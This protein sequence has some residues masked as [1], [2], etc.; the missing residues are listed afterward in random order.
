MRKFF[1]LTLASLLAVAAWAQD[2]SK[3]SVSTQMFL[4]EQAG[5]ISFEKKADFARGPKR[6]GITDEMVAQ[7]AKYDRPIA[8]PV[9]VDGVKMI[10]AFVRVSDRSVV[11]ELEALGVVVE[12]E[13][14]DGT[15]FTTLIPVDKIA[16]VS[17][18]AKVSRIK[19][20]TKRR[21]LTNLARQDANVDDVLTYSTSARDAGLPNAYDGSGVLLG[22]IDTGID[23]QH[24]A[25]KDKD[26]NFRIK[27]AYCVT[28]SGWN[29]SAKEYGDGASNSLSSSAPT[30]DNSS[31]DH[32][33]HTS[34]TAGGSSVIIS[35]SSTTVTDDHAS[36]SY[37]GMAPGADLYLAGCD[38]SDTYLAN[39]FQKIVSYADSKGAP[40]VVSNSWGSQYGPH[41]GTGEFADITS[42]YFS[43]DN[44]NHI[45]LFAASN[46]AGTNGFS[47]SGT[48]TSSNPLGTVLNYNSDYGLTYFYGVLASAWTRSTNT[49][50]ACKLVVI[51]SS[52]VKQTE[53]SVNPSTNGSNVSLGSTYA[54]GT[55]VAYR[56]Y[57]EGSN[58]SQ[59]L[60]YTD[61]LQMRSGYK[62]AVQ[63]YPTNGSSVVDVWSGSA[64]TYYTSTPATSGYT[65][66][67]GTDDM[68]VSDEACFPNVISVGA[69]S[70]KRTVTDYNNSS[71]TLS[72]YTLGDIAS[73]SSYATADKS[74][75][76]LAY[77][78]IC[79]S[80]ATVVSA[81]NAYDT[82]GDYSYINGNSATY[83]MYRVNKDT[84]NPY[85][86]MEGTSMATPAAAGIVALWLQVAKDN[87]IQLT[88]SDI[89]NIMKETAKHDSYTDGAH[90]SHFGNGK[91]DAL[92]GIE[93]ILNN[94]VS[95]LDKPVLN[96][97][98]DVT[99]TS[100]TASWSAVADANSY[101]LEVTQKP[102][103]PATI[104]DVI[105]NAFTGVGTSTNYST[106]SGKTGDSGAVYA[107]NS[108]GGNGSVQLRSTNS[109]SGIVTTATGGTVK[110]VKVTWNSG[111]TTGRTLD[112]Y[113]SSTA[114]SA[115]SDLYSSSTR[116]TKIGSI[117]CGTST[118]LEISDDYKFVGVRSNSGAMYLT[119]ITFTWEPAGASG[120]PRLNATDSGNA[121]TGTRTIS[122][123]TGTSYNVTGLTA[124]N[125]YIYKVKAI[126]NDVE[127]PWSDT[128][129][130][131]LTGGTPPAPT[132][133]VNPA[134]VNFT[135]DIYPNST[136]TQTFTVTGANLTAG[137]TL[138]L[139]GDN[140][141]LFSINPASLT[142]AQAEAGA[143][144]TVTY[145]PIAVGT[146]T[147]IVTATST[148]AEDA[149][150]SLN[151]TCV[152]APLVVY[153][154]VMTEA[155][156]IT[157]TS[158]NAVWTDQTVAE[159]VASYT[160]FVNKHEDAPATVD[161]VIDNAF[162]G[163]GTTSTY[164]GWT[165]K[166]G[167]SGAVYAGNSAGTNG[168]V[169]LRTTN[170][171]SGIVTTGS[172][173]K[174]RKVSVT[175]NSTTA[176]GR[177]LNVYGKNEAYTAATDLY[178]SN[179]RGTLIG[180]IVYGTSTELEITDD[181]TYVGVRSNGSAM[182]FDDITF[183]WEPAAA[184]GAPRL[185]AT[186]TGDANNGGL[187]VTGITEKQYTVTGLTAGETYDFK[188]KALYTDQNESSW[189]NTEQV[190]MPGNVPS[191]YITPETYDFGNVNT[192]E[193]ASCEFTLTGEYLTG[194]VMLSLNNNL[195]SVDPIT[196]SPV[197]GAINTT[198][199][200]T[201]AP[202]E[203]G[204]Q[205]ATLTLASDDV[206]T[207]SVALT[208][209]G[210]LVKEV[211][212]MAEAEEVT[213]ESFKAVWTDE[214]PEDNVESYTLFVN[215]YE[216]TPEPTVT[217]LLSETFPEDKFDAEGTADIGA[218]LDNF[219][220][221]AGWTGS[222]VYKM[223]GG[224]RLGKGRGTGELISPELDL[225]N[226]GGKVTVVYDVNAYN[227][228]TNVNYSITCG[229][230]T[231]S[232][233]IADNTTATETVVLDCEEA[234]GQTI[235]FATLANGKRIV[236]TS[237]KIYAGDATAAASGAPRLMAT[238]SGDAD[239]GGLTV[240]G[241]TDKEYNVTGLT[242]GATYNFKVKAVYV[243]ETESEWS[244]TEVVTLPECDP[245][246]L[247][248]ILENNPVDED[249]VV[250][251]DL[252]IVKIVASQ[253][254]AFATD[255]EGNWIELIV[256]EQ[257]MLNNLEMISTAA[258]ESIKGVYGMDGLNPAITLRE[259]PEASQNDVAVELEVYPV[260]L[261]FAPKTNEVFYITGF[262]H[263]TGGTDNG[264]N[265]REWTGNGGQYGVLLDL[266]LDWARG[267]MEE[268]KHYK[269][270]ATSRLKEA[271][272]EPE[273]SNGIRPMVSHD[274]PMALRNYDIYAIEIPNETTAIDNLL[275]NVDVKRVRY[276]NLQGVELREPADG[277]NIIVIE[278]TDGTF[279]TS[280]IRL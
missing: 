114:Y 132:I 185:M 212:V 124:G 109:N 49:T 84:T 13:F 16:E 55:L 203:A 280:K 173:G 66:T 150:V 144:V 28:S 140:A 224:V 187:T 159:N 256:P 6:I 100:F 17:E 268:G 25:F 184:N 221:N 133:T 80:G 152:A 64:Y 210:V 60:L 31:E 27:R 172:G 272:D 241:I 39:S 223:V 98:T 255:G 75:T 43:D 74:P 122:G 230:G 93:Y 168:T 236:L 262:Y 96:D 50:L 218:T 10:S 22:V 104:D 197:D 71:H 5:R 175:W 204:T 24:K 130:V 164:S 72:E 126:G 243:D 56:D 233:T 270:C 234:A 95:S 216:E 119:D 54:S 153:D 265:L 47:V 206:E 244:N 4:D 200:V 40:V 115:A 51:N 79:A 247:A 171:N 82:N 121:D 279:T 165:G 41:D 19:V 134:T 258:G 194:D 3:F 141:A 87:D 146:H 37:G 213:S 189:S 62:L 178:N 73:F 235:S 127:S 267:N 183:T 151:G 21:P 81:V 174:V 211:P 170:N 139:S 112:V 65:W 76:G 228:D 245:S 108:A 252:A 237:I 195:F 110:K 215:K 102:E 35:G 158:F 12:C 117:V 29:S 261:Y 135:G 89:K 103:V 125:T 273:A 7:Y 239:N 85:G 188:V 118:E 94:Y 143:T 61:Q 86:S 259:S 181:Y 154:P 88:T 128:K 169:Q 192:G 166:T 129:E 205:N 20:A 208:G 48:A 90:A 269:I 207:L 176:T 162:T 45:C 246:T 120:A 177:T 1:I 30:T 137:V 217:L 142:Q 240:T 123:I 271:W 14:L 58:K 148:D 145:T 198:V 38:L 196:V 23:F 97:P 248:Q 167:T 113:G 190:T 99:N 57:V 101:T 63:F 232:K 91:I 278:H 83:G 36:A 2:A 52:G 59:I 263:A 276:Y 277:I 111:T 266:K 274:D 227:N 11:S 199:T 225:S 220:E 107:G 149:V 18:L 231:E 260:D 67:A 131:E 33:T 257:E 156:E 32:G 147:A 238:E 202:T 155:Q 251:N 105:D 46:D 219:M 163:V 15:L 26:G 275:Q 180:T 201:F 70:T 253:N 78:W 106:W 68:C 242:P 249:V 160:L 138:A 179:N 44:P 161:D 264:A 193:T 69:Y 186:E 157:S 182:Y 77:P 136:N 92:A 8:A 222:T 229:V 34:S 191:L 214:T 42:Q 116:G 250:A 254:I 226:S 209:N 53:V 9:Y